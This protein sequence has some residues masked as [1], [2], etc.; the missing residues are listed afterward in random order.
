MTAP[1][2]CTKRLLTVAGR[3]GERMTSRAAIHIRG[4]GRRD[5]K[6]PAWLIRDVSFVINPGERLAIVGATG[7]GKTVLLRALGFL[8][9]STRGRSIGAVNP[10]M[11]RLFQRIGPM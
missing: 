3:N 11:A 7:A 6:S 5:S 2:L 9:R 1:G 8:I 4:L 10:C